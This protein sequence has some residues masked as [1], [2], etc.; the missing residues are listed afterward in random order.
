MIKKKANVVIILLACTSP[1]LT[2]AANTAFQDFLSNTCNSA[3]PGS[4][5][6]TRCNVDSVNGDL[7]GDSEDSLNPTQSLANGANAIAETR[8]RIKAL[9]AKMK[10]ERDKATD[11]AGDEV[12]DDIKKVFRVSGVSLL[13]NGENG[14]LDKDATLLER[15]YD[16]DNTRIQLGFDYRVNNNWI[17]GALIGFD[18]YD[19]T[20]DADAPG[21]NFAPG[22]SEGDSEA[23]S[24]SISLFTSTSFAKGFYFDALASYTRSDY[25]FKRIGLF[26]ETTRTLPTI[27]VNT[28]AETNGNQ[29]AFGI[30]L[31]WDKSFG[32]NT[33]Q[34]Y[35]RV[36]HTE[37]SID[38][39]TEEGGA[40][41][42]MR[43]ENA[44]TRETVGSYGFKFSHSINT[45]FGILVP[46]LFVEY[47]N[48]INSDANN[49]LSSFIEDTTNSQFRSSGDDPDDAYTRVGLS[50]L[51]GFPNRWTAF[52]GVNK[53][54]AQDNIDELRITAGI[55]LEL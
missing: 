16:T 29:S 55:R 52:I 54:Y 44:D 18:S 30:G 40:G 46:Q 50:I 24:I 31:G 23:D 48:A 27:A 13:I 51:G 14:S 6:D 8:A 39:Y 9:H 1:G 42:A 33:I 53:V 49:S 37:S 12:P 7:S 21:R 20:Y 35:S 5:F 38:T 22:D 34:L 28:S 41:F 11:E 4:D 25:T 47:E 45:S 19:T 36:S 43:I 10:E 3:N 2:F 32:S 15:G 26:Q 17:I